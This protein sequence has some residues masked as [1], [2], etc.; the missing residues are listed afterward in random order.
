MRNKSFFG[1]ELRQ[2]AAGSSSA[3]YQAMLDL[4]ISVMKPQPSPYELIRIGGD[5]DGSY[6]VPDALEGIEACFS[7]GVNNFKHFEDYLSNTYGI[8]SHMCDYSSDVEKLATPLIASMQTFEKLWLEPRTSE[9]SISLHDWVNKRAP[10]DGDLLLQIDIEG[11][12]YRNIIECDE[13]T[14]SRFKVIVIELHEMND[15]LDEDVVREV[16]Y[17]FFQKLNNIFTCI[18][19]HPNNCCGDL[20]LPN[21][22]IRIPR[23]LELTL[24][25]NDFFDL[26]LETIAPVI[27]HPLDV[28][29]N[30]KF[31]PPLFLDEEWINGPRVAEARIKMLMDR[32]AYLEEQPSQADTNQR[33][34]GIE[35]SIG[36]L[37][38][39]LGQKTALP[40][41]S[42][43]EIAEGKPYSL[44]SSLLKNADRGTVPSEGKNFFFHTKCLPLQHITIDLLG[45]RNISRIS[46]DNRTDACFERAKLVFAVLHNDQVW[47][48]EDY[49][50]AMPIGKDFLNGSNLTV[51]VAVPGVNAR[52]VSLVS[53]FANFFHLSAI[54]VYTTE[55]Q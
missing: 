28:G 46:I 3:D 29:R 47:T 20:A 27:P 2:P 26:G 39:L 33:L 11:A 1:I 41:S 12:E 10:G 34:D 45:A 18:H 9:D 22:G 37:T 44:S 30:A 5:K 54:R 8:K 19:A 15:L 52:Y 23:V 14:L 31:K 35:H 21:R 36:L 32:V 4:V 24:L 7:P 43:R 49:I 13:K 50:A 42:L 25:R 38:R 53:P 16:F 51:D 40:P 17:P 55:N 48:M 6:L